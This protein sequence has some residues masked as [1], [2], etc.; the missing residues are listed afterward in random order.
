MTIKIGN[1]EI[2]DNYPCF[3]IFEAGPTHDGPETA[4]RLVRLA[5]EAGADAIK[6]QIFNPDKLV[7]ERNIILE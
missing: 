1:R 5:A 4:T 6:F 7:A 2:G 3:I